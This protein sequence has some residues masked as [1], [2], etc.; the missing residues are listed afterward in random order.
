MALSWMIMGLLTHYMSEPQ[1]Y[2]SS[3]FC[4]SYMLY[5]ASSWFNKLGLSLK[6]I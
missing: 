1:E 3:V 6:A 5:M 2:L 4:N